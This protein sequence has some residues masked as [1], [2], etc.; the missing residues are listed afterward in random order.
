[1]LAILSS[2]IK[3]K[4]RVGRR[5]LFSHFRAHE[6]EAIKERV[7]TKKKEHEKAKAPSAKK[8]CA[9]SSL[10]HLMLGPRAQICSAGGKARVLSKIYDTL[11]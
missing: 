2:R 6:C 8:I 1:M 7:S 4:I 10:P 11:C 9:F 5:H 3:V